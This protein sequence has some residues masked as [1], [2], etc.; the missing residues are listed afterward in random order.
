MKL[1]ASAS[2][3]N[4]LDSPDRMRLIDQPEALNVSRHENPFFDASRAEKARDV[5]RD[6]A[7]WELNHA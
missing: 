5:Y 6:Q 7:F 2:G 3:V 1:G 4:L